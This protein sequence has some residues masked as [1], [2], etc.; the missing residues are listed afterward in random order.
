MW[1]CRSGGQ[2]SLTSADLPPCVGE[3]FAE[4]SHHL[5]ELLRACDERRRDLDDGIAAVVGAAD[6][7]PLEQLRRQ[8][9]AQR[10][11][12]LL[13]RERLA[14]LL[15]LPELE[16]PQVAGT[17]QVADDVEVEQRRELVTE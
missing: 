9:A 4:N 8:E 5:G 3:H 14:R 15:V 7:P 10:G 2:P 1:S 11:L 16:R 17:A 13:V 6:Q 12:G